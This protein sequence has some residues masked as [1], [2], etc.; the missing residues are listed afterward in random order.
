M[1]L[2]RERCYHSFSPTCWGTSSKLYAG[3]VDGQSFRFHLFLKGLE[4]PEIV[5][6]HCHLQGAVTHCGWGCTLFSEAV[7]QFS[8]KHCNTPTP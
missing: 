1:M 2:E 7:K 6:K 4:S 5:N 3:C 8:L